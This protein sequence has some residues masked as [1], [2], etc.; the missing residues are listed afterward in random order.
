MPDYSFEEKGLKNRDIASKVLTAVL[1][2][3]A[4][5]LAWRVFGGHETR[6]EDGKVVLNM[7]DVPNLNATS[8][9]ARAAREVHI[10]FLRA[11]PEIKVVVTRGV[12]VEGAASSS[13]FYTA[14]AGG[15][16]PDLFRINMRSIG[17][18][19]EEGF[20]RPLDDF[21]EEDPSVA[22]SISSVIK[23]AV[24]RSV[25]E[26]GRKVT[27]T[28]AIPAE[29]DVMGFYYRKSLFQEFGLPVDGCPANEWNWDS[30]WEYS[31]KLTFPEQGYYGLTLPMGGWGGWMWMNFV[32][33]ADGEI[34]RQYGVHPRTGEYI[35][36]PSVD[37]PE[38][39]W[40][41]A[42][43]VDL[44][45]VKQVWRAVYDEPAGIEALSF[46]RK[47]RW[48]P[49]TRCQSLQCRGKNVCYDI[50]AEMAASAE[51]K[52]PVCGAQVPI[53]TLEAQKRYYKGVLF[54]DPSN[55]NTEET[56]PFYTEKRIGMMMWTAGGVFVAATQM[57]PDEIGVMPCPA[58]PRGT[59]A[60][61]FNAGHWGINAQLKD[62]RRLQ[63]A[64]DY[65]KFQ[66]S[67]EADRIRVSTLV[68]AGQGRYVD[69]KRLV[70]Y[71]FEEYAR[72]VP[73]SWAETYEELHKYGRVEP[74]APNYKN[75]QTS[76][77][78]IFI[79]AIFTD[80]RADPATVLH[81]SAE[82]VN[83]TIFQEILQA[84][85]NHRRKV[86]YVVAAVALVALV[87]LCVVLARGV[88]G[89]VRA[90]AARKKMGLKFAQT[91]ALSA[92]AFM[93]PAVLT[94]L[95]WDYA[96]LVRG[97]VMAFRDF[98]IVGTSAWVGLDNFIMVFTDRVFYHSLWVT[99]YYVALAL[100]MQFTAPIIL[101]MLLAEVPRGK[102]LYRVIYYLPAITSGLVIMFLWKKFYDPST[103][104]FNSVLSYLG[105]P[106]SDWLSSGNG[107]LPMLCVVLPMVWA[108]AG[109]GSLIYLAALKSVPEEMYEASDI[110]G[111]STW[112]KVR[113][114]TLPY[115]KP[116]IIIN[117]VGAFIGAFQAM[118]QIF[119]MTGGGPAQA[120][121]VIGLEIWYNAYMY[122]K[123]GYATAQAWVLG[124]MLIGFTVYQLQIL[125]KV[126]FTTAKA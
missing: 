41:A 79:D 33:Q 126:K 97:A 93:L 27:R 70:K 47:L 12:M 65:I 123:F 40:V 30:L 104:L 48:A 6:R 109:A 106:T 84:V 1:L 87:G 8:P 125:K 103:G 44:R 28:Y 38:E 64:W 61:A 68:E 16:A 101:G 11:H 110:D 18:Y 20:V 94:I 45:E 7:W 50:T 112:Q 26:N 102:I 91:S 66:T 29:T 31:K 51:A 89:L 119:V 124:L 95:V 2:L 56:G 107:W 90:G 116:L 108:G 15:T 86:A 96:P 105:L 78:A 115:L 43:G 32:W 54:V 58:G 25:V 111:A 9:D 67:D 77:M 42:D 114:I 23:P 73:R 13:A 39:E 85:M 10:A 88:A 57:N 83:S 113:L 118:Q 92:W 117:F 80:E 46:Y 122:L 71:G 17:S 74:Y 100:T 14:M 3:T 72:H 22:A 5:L 24:T 19:I 76:A 49:W 53:A 98:R 55:T 60:N 69:P 120:T 52:C 75:V 81:K 99:L 63:A 36:L 4:A 59:R 21:V 121:H 37:A 35:P 34:V 82:S 62:P